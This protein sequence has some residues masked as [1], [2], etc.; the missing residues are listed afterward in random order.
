MDILF[1]M[2]HNYLSNSTI[3][4]HQFANALSEKGHKCAICVP[5][6][7]DTISNISDKVLYENIDYQESLNKE[8]IFFN[9]KEPEIIHA[10]T[11]REIVRKQHEKLK[12]KFPNSKLVIHLED[13]EEI[14]IESNLHQTMSELMDYSDEKLESLIPE[15]LSH[16]FRYKSFLESSSACTIIIDKLKEFVPPE[17]RTMILWPIIDFNRFNIKNNS[18]LRKNYK[19]KSNEIVISYTGNVHAANYR[20]V[21]SLY[22]AVVLANKEGIPCKMIRTGKDYV[23]FLGDDPAWAK[24]YSIELGFINYN[25]IP[26]ILNASDIL[27]QPGKPDRFNIYRL[28]SKIPEFLATGIPVVLPNTNLGFHL[29]QNLNCKLMKKGDA[30]EI[31]NIIR[32]FYYNRDQF[33]SIGKKGQEFCIYNFKKEDICS[34]LIEFYKKL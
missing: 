13:N 28:P 9:N 18:E 12:E 17:I 34:Q 32:E 27:I 15:N 10:W 8:L 11:P 30:S 24:K 26:D 5:E 6:G 31:L 23:N 29:T 1:L 16:P 3:Q 25:R 19:I 22:L 20:E 4:V 33:N 21:R 2:Y 7:K 14:I